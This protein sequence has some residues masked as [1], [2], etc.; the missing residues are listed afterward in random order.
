MSSTESPEFLAA[1]ASVQERLASSGADSPAAPSESRKETTATAVVPEGALPSHLPDPAPAAVPD[2]APAAPAFPAAGPASAQ[3][4]GGSTLT[5]IPSDQALERWGSGGGVQWLA[6]YERMARLVAGTV[7]LPDALKSPRDILAVALTGRELG[8]GFMEATRLIQIIKGRPALAAE[9]KVRKAIEAGHEIR[10]LEESAE[11]VTATCATHNASA[12]FSMADAKKAG[13]L[14]PDSGW[15]KY[16]SDMMWARAATR[17]IRR[18]CPEVTG[19]G[20]RSIEELSD[21]P[22]EVSA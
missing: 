10:V 9:L 22:I 16:A 3:N 15:E 6:E 19:A 2:P 14:K 11:E 13:L 8:L 5:V 20:L 18:H 12:S 21:A 17:L 1:R 7:T 4:G